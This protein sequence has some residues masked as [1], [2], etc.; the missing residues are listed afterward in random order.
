M[1]ERENKINLYT[2][3]NNIATGTP[4]GLLSFE[5]HGPSLKSDKS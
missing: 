3:Y 2:R 4:K 5:L 1:F